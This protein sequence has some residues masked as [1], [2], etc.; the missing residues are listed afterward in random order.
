MKN[1]YKG[2]GSH[3]EN[4]FKYYPNPKV[5]QKIYNHLRNMKRRIELQEGLTNEEKKRLKNL[6]KEIFEDQI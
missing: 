3:E 6:E 1:P 4:P 5:L 2:K